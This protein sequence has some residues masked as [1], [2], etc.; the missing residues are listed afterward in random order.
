MYLKIGAIL[1]S[2][3]SMHF[4]RKHIF[5]ALPFWLGPF[6]C[7]PFWRCPFRCWSILEWT[8]LARI[9]WK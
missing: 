8:L 6:C 7:G 9:L 5:L 3:I 4:Y 2:S 1:L